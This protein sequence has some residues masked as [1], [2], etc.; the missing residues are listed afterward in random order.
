MLDST[1]EWIACKSSPLYFFSKYVYI[2]NSASSDNKVIKWESWPYLIDTLQAFQEHREIIILKARQLGI[3]WLVC[4]YAVWQMTFFPNSNILM[5]SKG[6][7]EAWE[8]LRK[9]RF[10]HRRLPTF[11]RKTIGHDNRGGFEFPENES[12]VM[13]LSSSA[14]AGVGYTATLV[15]R[16]ELEEHP[17]GERNF[18][19]IGPCIDAGGKL[20]EL[21]THSKDTKNTH[22]IERYRRAKSGES[23]GYPMFLGWRLRPVRDADL[24]LDEWYERNIVR[25]YT[26][27]QRE[28]LYPETEQE[29]LSQISTNSFFDKEATDIMLLDKLPPIETRHSGIIKIW[30]KPVVGSTYFAYLDPSDGSEDPHCA[31]VLDSRTFEVVAESWGKVKADVCAMYFDELV[32]EYNNAFN[33]F[34]KNS[35]AGGMVSEKLNQLQTPNRRKGGK[36]KDGKDKFGLYV[37]G[38]SISS[39]R[40]TL[41]NALEEAIRKHL[42]IVHDMDAV[43]EIQEFLRPTGDNPCPPAG[44]HDD[45]IMALAGAWQIRKEIPTATH[46]KT[47]YCVGYGRV[48]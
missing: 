48:R 33:E 38:N 25:K 28:G 15:V 24:T 1:V 45:Y 16:D 9:C 46:F 41:L 18:A 36:D 35:F 20:I 40:N 26:K 13:A 19:F 7:A 44:G 42:I 12:R 47:G 3:S 34:E 37:S 43:R 17:E 23:N 8:M 10:I 21:S 5:L 32:R 27:W 14:S 39:L 6:E 2:E 30:K 4:G 22:F 31:V 29:A 11:L